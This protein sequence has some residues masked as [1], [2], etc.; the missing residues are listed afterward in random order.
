MVLVE[1]TS[2]QPGID[3]V[4]WLLVMIFMWIYNENEQAMQGKP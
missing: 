3:C 2:K 4:T 1:E